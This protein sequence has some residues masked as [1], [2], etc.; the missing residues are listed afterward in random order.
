M[1]VVDPQI[2]TASFIV[3][4]AIMMVAWA[5]IL[6]KLLNGSTFNPYHIAGFGAAA[7]AIYLLGQ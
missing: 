3:T 6:D 2:P 1:K 4:T 5:P 7:L